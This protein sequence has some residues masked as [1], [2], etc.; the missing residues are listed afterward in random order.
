MPDLGPI[1]A[2][3]FLQRTL[4]RTLLYILPDPITDV[5]QIYPIIT[6]ASCYYDALNLKNFIDIE[7]IGGLRG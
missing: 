1:A 7:V 2:Y 6:I 4:Q 5:L 3:E